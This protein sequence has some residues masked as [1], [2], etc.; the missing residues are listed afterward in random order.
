MSSLVNVNPD[1][2]ETNDEDSYNTLDLSNHYE[3]TTTQ[4]KEPVSLIG[5]T[6]ND[7]FKNGTKC[8]HKAVCCMY[9][10][11]KCK[12]HGIKKRIS[13][14]HPCCAIVDID[15]SGKLV[16]CP[17][18]TKD[19]HFG[20]Y[21]C[22]EHYKFDMN[23]VNE[24]PE[25]DQCAICLNRHTNTV[26]VTN[27]NTFFQFPFHHETVEQTRHEVCKLKCGHVFHRECILSWFE[28]EPINNTESSCPV[29][30]QKTDVNTGLIPYKMYKNKLP[31]KITY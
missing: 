5:K 27:H 22:D 6:C 16:H 3:H 29:C 10:E 11:F 14:G 17:N 31:I 24:F 19:S 26:F 30:R 28:S 20:K 15:T 25:D 12:Q 4:P 23:R 13:I 8:N 18:A 2:F 1:F 9:G 21:L 7:V